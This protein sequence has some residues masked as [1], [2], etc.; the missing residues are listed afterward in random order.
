MSESRP[1]VVVIGSGF[2]GAVVACRL[3]QAGFAVTILERGRR[4]PAG[5]APNLPQDGALLPDERRWSWKIDQGLWEV[6]DLDEVVSVQAAAY[7]GGSIVY[8]NV[9][10]RPPREVFDEAWPAV[11]RD[12]TALD[13]YYDLV[14][15]ML[16]VAPVSA[17]PDFMS[18]IT[19]SKQLDGAAQKLGR[20]VFFPPLAVRYT[21]GRNAHQVEQN[22][23]TGCG[24]CCTGCPQG[25]KNTLDLNY[26]AIAERYGARVFTQ[27][28]VLQLIE[29]PHGSWSILCFDHL[30]ARRVT[31]RSAHV[32]LC[33]GSLHST[34]LMARSQLIRDHPRPPPDERKIHKR[35]GLGYFPGGDAL[36]LVYETKHPQRPSVGPVITTSLVEWSSDRPGSFFMLQDGG[37]PERA[38]E[39]VGLLRASAFLHGNRLT[40]KGNATVPALQPPQSPSLGSPKEPFATSRRPSF[41]DQVL[42]ARADGAF[43]AVVPRQ[44]VGLTKIVA[45]R[46]SLPLLMSEIVRVAVEKSLRHR[47]RWLGWLRRLVALIGGL[48]ARIFLGPFRF[49]GARALRSLPKGG[50]LHR[51]QLL[52]RIAGISAKDGERRA[53]LLAMGRDSAG[54]ELYYSH[55]QGRLIA[56]LNLARLAPGYSDQESLMA[57]VSRQLGG[58]LRNNPAWEFLHKPIT[59]HNQGGCRMADAAPRGGKLQG[60]TDAN[61]KVWGCSGL[62]ILDGSVL[63]ASVGVNPAP[64]IAAIAERGVLEF[65]RAHHPAFPDQSPGGREY[66]QQIEQ[67]KL[68]AAKA[69]HWD[70]EPPAAPPAPPPRPQAAPIGLRFSEEMAGYY[71]ETR[72]RPRDYA[73][74]LEHEA[75]GRPH[76]P[77]RLQ[78]EVSVADLK[79]FME[80]PSHQMTFGGWVDI[81]LPGDPI[82]HIARYKITKG[83]LKLLAPFPK[84]HALRKNDERL[85][86]QTAIMCR[87]WHL[88]RKRTAV[89]RGEPRLRKR[90]MDYALEFT[91][92]AQQVWSVVG[93]KRIASTASFDAWRQTATLHVRLVHGRLNGDPEWHDT[94][95]KEDEPHDDDAPPSPAERRSVEDPPP[96]DLRGAGAVHVDLSSFLDDTLGKLVATNA[97]DK[98]RAAWAVGEFTRFFFG[99]LQR[100]YLPALRNVARRAGTPRR[101]EHLD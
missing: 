52:S 12:R 69:A 93:R 75:K 43:G 16:E 45:K 15:S 9:H 46:L 32:F 86:L 36:G 96:E 99:T 94:N 97:V 42:D 44:L 7:G 89:R 53:V 51:H 73:H 28:E 67:S 76:F 58:E 56:N 4:Y 26:L 47:F 30:E 55:E 81:R 38:S 49:V 98:H 10:L 6:I 62:Y 14:A 78:L 72:R 11:F 64:T 27:F 1:E 80:D 77:I 41:I 22:K 37:Y 2:G 50:G 29:K 71:H 13:P 88:P 82:G 95:S 83:S 23:C 20:R 101:L 79:A 39:L 65:I 90:R 84:E 34:E 25:A 57:D 8:A 31:L 3:A 87:V 63:C 68:W 19:K 92:D 17:H 100:I 70:L 33:T 35:V 60:V 59:V 66:S 5:D 74:Y 61:G 40:R 21:D 24:A 18:E 48:I 91:D 54:G 85:G